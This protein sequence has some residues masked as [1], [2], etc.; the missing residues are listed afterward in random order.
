LKTQKLVLTAL[1][2]ALSFVGANFFIPGTTIALDAMPAFLGA[3]WIGP[4]AGGLI[5][6][7][8]HF[9]TA[10]LR[11]FPLSLPVHAVVM[12]TMAL[13]MAG[14]G[15]VY[16]S[17]PYGRG[18][19]SLLAFAVG[20]LLNVPF[21]LYMVSLVIGPGIFAMMPLLAL[22][23]LANILIALILYHLL[24]GRGARDE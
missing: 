5:G 20:I 21:S 11:G 18:V 12:A 1:F 8:G 6:G 9:F 14:F 10:L 16:R 4:L 15:L 23:A 13:T 19:K 3:L 24:K 17:V 7:L 2:T 22:G